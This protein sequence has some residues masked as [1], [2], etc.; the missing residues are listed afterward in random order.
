MDKIYLT[1]FACL[2]LF[3]A[4]AQKIHLDF[5]KNTAIDKSKP[6]V[7]QKD[8][9][10]KYDYYQNVTHSFLKAGYNVVSGDLANPNDKASSYFI[11]YHIGVIP[12]KGADDFGF[13]MTLA[14][15]ASGKILASGSCSGQKSAMVTAID[16]L[17]RQ[18]IEKLTAGDAT[19]H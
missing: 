2:A 6:V 4:G 19:P 11:E 16:D 1:A 18:F 17:I 13:E 5:T 8:K 15:G 14:D 12:K 10:D 7:I 9:R 3:S